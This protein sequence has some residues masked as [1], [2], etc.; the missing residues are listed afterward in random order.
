MCDAL[1]AVALGGRVFCFGV[2]DDPVYPIPMQLLFRKRAS[3]SGGI[4]TERRRCQAAALVY[5]R[6][7]PDLHQRSHPYRRPAGGPEQAR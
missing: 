3:L 2:P 6:R 5:H 7:F 1:A 4:V